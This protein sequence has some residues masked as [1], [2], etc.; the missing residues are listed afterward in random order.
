MGDISHEQYCHLNCDTCEERA[1][2]VC[3]RGCVVCVVKVSVNCYRFYLVI[4]R[5]NKKFHQ[6]SESIM[7]VYLVE[8]DN[9]N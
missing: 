9:S 2:C 3:V 4:A 6:V 7:L 1:H 8:F 5:K